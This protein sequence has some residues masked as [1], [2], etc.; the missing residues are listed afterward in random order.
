MI[1]DSFALFVIT[2]P[3]L[4]LKTVRDESGVQARLDDSI[5]SEM[6][7]VVGQY[8]FDNIVSEKREEIFE[9]VTRSS[10]AKA[11]ELSIEIKTVRMK[12]VSVPEEN[13]RKIYDSMIAERQRQAALYRAEM[14]REAQ[15]IKSEA[16]KRRTIILAEA[17]RKAKELKGQGE[18]EAGRIIQSAL[19]A[20]PEFYQFI[21]SLEVYKKTIP[22][23]TIIITP[24]SE[25]FKYLRSK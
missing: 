21:K 2:D 15:R 24:D 1:L 4:F 9:E 22:G 6:R 8:D 16:E 19:S 17:Y 20:N 25:I 12:R 3:L 5:Y 13:L 23:N 18:A 10:Q 14:Q 11:M 7:R